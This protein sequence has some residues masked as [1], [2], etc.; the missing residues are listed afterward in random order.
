MI[1]ASP[2][3]LTLAALA[4]VLVVFP[5]LAETPPS[6]G[7]ARIAVGDTLT[8]IQRPLLSIPTIVTAGSAFTIS[9]AADPATT[10]WA[11]SLRG[12]EGETT[13]I[14]TGASYD[15]STLWWSLVAEVPLGTVARLYDLCLTADGGLL[16]D[17]H[18]SV[19]VLEHFEN[20]YYF[21]HITDSHLPTHLYWDGWDMADSNATEDLREVIEDINI[22]NPEFVLH[23][24]DLVNEGELEDYEDRRV[25]TRAKQLLGELTVP[26]YMVAGNHD[27][28]GWTSTPPSAG[29]ARRDW[30][31]FFGW[32]RLDDPPPGAPL[33]TQNF[34]FDY[35]T[36]HYVGMEA[37]VNYDH[38]REWYYDY[39]SFPSAQLD[40]LD[41]DLAAA[42][43]TDAQVLFFH[44]DFQDQ[45]DL[46][47]LGVEMALYGHIHYDHGSIHSM[48][49]NLATDNTC[50]G[51]RA[52]RLI[53]VTNGVLMPTETVWSGSNG[54]NLSVNYSPANDGTNDMVTAT[55]SNHTGE[56]F[57]YGQLRFVMPAGPG[58]YTVSGGT[59]DRIEDVIPNAIC[60]VNV[61]I[62]A[63]GSIVAS[64]VFEAGVAAPEVAPAHA[65]LGQNYPNPFN[66]RTTIRFELPAAQSISL[67]VHS[68]DGRKLTQL[69]TGIRPAGWSEVEWDGNDG[70][71]RPLPS[72]TYLYK[73]TGNEFSLTRRMTLLR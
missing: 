68:L 71:G 59:L 8:V 66:P 52:F 28:G 21:I 69:T 64:V 22:I 38:W 1:S 50:D 31:R 9:C 47:S 32:A 55:V 17:T 53:R 35:G 56:R 29:T 45:L 42:S 65:R 33:R 49:F 23:T 37:Y 54:N 44:M 48:P 11:A 7:K 73:L 51:D 34:S 70:L 30:W 25:Y 72:G 36:V 12:D 13:L 18:N 5:V 61:M 46:S 20:S 40:W 19:R 41:A 14:I 26:V 60:Y 62:P 57:E 67:S 43:G 10:G 6:H 3:V 27:L 24:G 2:K 4:A 63:N 15:A 16:D 39:Y 58:D